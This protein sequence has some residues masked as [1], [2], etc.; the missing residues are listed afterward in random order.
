MTHSAFLLWETCPLFWLF[1][2]QTFFH[3][4]VPGSGYS[5]LSGIQCRQT[6]QTS[7]NPEPD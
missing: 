6:F 3:L 1:A 2:F 7:R 4:V 5:W